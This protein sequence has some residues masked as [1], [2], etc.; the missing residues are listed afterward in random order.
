ML[1][2]IYRLRQR[3]KIEEATFCQFLPYG[4][5]VIVDFEVYFFLV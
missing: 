5:T 2:M 4:T 1:E 3:R